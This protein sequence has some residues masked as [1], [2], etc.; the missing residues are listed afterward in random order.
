MPQERIYEDDAWLPEEERLALA[1]ELIDQ[2]RRKLAK[3][4][5]LAE[6]LV[7]AYLHRY[8]QS[9]KWEEEESNLASGRIRFGIKGVFFCINYSSGI[10]GSGSRLQLEKH[11][12]PNKEGDP[13]LEMITIE[14]NR[15]N[16]LIVKRHGLFQYLKFEFDRKKS[17]ILI[18]SREA[19]QAIR[20]FIQENLPA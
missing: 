3:V 8:Y 10:D 17:K 1:T 13:P 11:L 18:C 19:E 12:H 14:L 7:K 9:G 2:T 16:G 6:A 15:E 20:Q 5:E 4:P